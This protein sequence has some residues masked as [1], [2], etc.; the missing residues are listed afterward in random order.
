MGSLTMG[1]SYQWEKR[2]EVIPD[3]GL[4]ICKSIARYGKDKEMPGWTGVPQDMQD[5]TDSNPP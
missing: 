5:M 3:T 2:Q 1:R 4:S